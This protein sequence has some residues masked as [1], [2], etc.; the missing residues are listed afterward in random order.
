MYTLGGGIDPEHGWGRQADTY[1]VLDELRVYGVEP[2]WFTLGDKDLATH[3]VRTQLLTAGY[4]L[5]EITAALCRRWQPGVTLVPMTDDRVETHVVVQQ[6]DGPAA[7]HFQ[8]W[9]VQHRAALPACEFRFVG[10]DEARPGPGV[11][12]A[13]A[14]ADVVI[15]PPSNPVV[16][17]G[18]ILAVPGIRDA[19][20]H[21]PAPVVGVSGIVAGRPV[22]G[23]ADACLTAIGV[24]PT[25]AA[26]AGH[27][28]S[29]ADG[30]ILDGWV[31]EQGDPP[32]AGIARILA[33]STVM[34]DERATT[35]LARATVELVL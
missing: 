14:A 11:L 10:V 13:L 34:T 12:E 3:L 35:A 16:S 1:G 5:S 21:G 31:F 28:G 27:Y 19:V 25:S 8:Q 22:K 29:R 2:L 6:P 30:G 24:E 18:P 33:T 15:L 4:P 9:W 23:M 32:P 7:I 20:R 26:V 17:I